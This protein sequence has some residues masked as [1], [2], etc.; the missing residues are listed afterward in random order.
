MTY[1]KPTVD[2]RLDL[3]GRLQQSDDSVFSLRRVPLS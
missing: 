1:E 3:A 2:A